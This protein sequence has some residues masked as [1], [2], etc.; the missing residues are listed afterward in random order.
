MKISL[1]GYSN[2]N[3]R[4]KCWKGIECSIPFQN[5]VTANLLEKMGKLPYDYYGSPWEAE[6]DRLGGVHRTENNTSWPDGACRS[7]GDLLKM[8]FR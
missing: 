1:K 2:G 8:F 3:Y 7:Y 5:S 4:K 6:A